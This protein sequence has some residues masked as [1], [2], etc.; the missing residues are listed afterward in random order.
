MG[1]KEGHAK[2]FLCMLPHNL[3][4]IKIKDTNCPLN[5]EFKLNGHGYLRESVIL[6]PNL[7]DCLVV[8]EPIFIVS[9]DVDHVEVRDLNGKDSGTVVASGLRLVDSRLLH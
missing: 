3:I 1:P 4:K 6:E 7:L 2:L 5:S 9:L 8:H